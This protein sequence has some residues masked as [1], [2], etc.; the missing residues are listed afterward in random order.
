ML[1]YVQRF[2]Q[3]FASLHP[4]RQKLIIAPRNECGMSKFICT[5]L[6][7]TQL[8][9]QD[10]YEYD[11]CAAFVADFIHYEPL[12]LANQLPQH[13]PS[14]CATLSWQAGDCFDIAQ[15]SS[16]QC[17]RMMSWTIRSCDACH[18]S[19]V[20]SSLAWGMMHTWCQVTPPRRSHAATKQLPRSSSRVMSLWLLL[21]RCA[22]LPRPSLVRQPLTIVLRNDWL[23][24]GVDRRRP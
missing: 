23:L 1:V 12:E 2:E 7:P 22:C 15:A 5:T 24:C 19:Y 9:F 11:K 21:Q 3:H 4:D 20:R 17:R 13:V 16:V 6:R 10:V 8:P 18:R 14:P